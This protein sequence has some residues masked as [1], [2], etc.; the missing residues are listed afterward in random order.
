[1]SAKKNTLTPEEMLQDALVPAEEQ[2][3]EVPRNWVW[4]RF[5]S[6]FKLIGGG[7]PSKSNPI[8]WNGEMPWASV[9]DIKDTYLHFTAD[10][11]S[12]CGVENSSTS[13]ANVNEV[14][15]IT[16]MSP[17]KSTITKIKTAINQDLKIVRPLFELE[18]F[19]VWL[20]FNINKNSI[21]AN[22]TGT[23]VKGVR[24]E[25]INSIPFPLPP[26][27][28]QKRIAARVELLLD[29]INQAKDLIAEAR[30]TFADRR[31]AI[32]AKAFRGELT[33]KWRE[34]NPN[35]EP[36][37]KLLERIREEKAKQGNGKGRKQVEIPPIE[38]PYELPEGWRW[39]R[40]YDI[41]IIASNLVNPYDYPDLPHI[42]PDNIE[43]E[44]G[45]LKEYCT[46]AE[47]GV[48]SSKHFFGPG[49]ILYSKI[50]PNLSKC[51]LVEFEGLCSAD[52]YPINSFINTQYL[53]RYILSPIFLSFA[54][55]AGSR[56]VLPKINQEGLNKIP[57]PIPLEVEQDIIVKKIDQLYN[58]EEQSLKLYDIEN[59]LEIISQDT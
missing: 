31:A 56:T 17:G 21:E 13:I 15:L 51:V 12:L 45:I 43:K 46:V 9:K 25:D 38:P 44:T 55:N 23:T 50:R 14:L 42:A 33:K 20:F 54:T 34:Q 3:Y 26:L 35:T 7:T 39:V 29:K 53:F 47:S 18:P 16:R 40:F 10:H 41:A 19:F 4:V 6:I 32:L 28:E 52:M 8:Y 22:A 48:K 59:E 1:M 57:V 11:I 27:S 58:F 37:E 24:I 49:Q 30:E 36:A 5:G 2:P